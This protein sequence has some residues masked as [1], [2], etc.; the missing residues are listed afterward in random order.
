MN[1][2]DALRHGPRVVTALLGLWLVL[3]PSLWYHDAAQQMNAWIVGA[4]I[5]VFALGGA[6]LDWMRYA[7]S[8][9]AVWLVFSIL[10][11]PP[12]ENATWWNNAIVGL[13]VLLLSFVPDRAADQAAVP[14]HPHPA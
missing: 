1:R 6:L 4:L 13:L 12:A 7:V 5:F 10:V 9:F 2:R 14:P 8:A 11:L 3:S